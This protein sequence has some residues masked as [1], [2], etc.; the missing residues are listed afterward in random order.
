MTSP[1]VVPDRCPQCGADLPPGD[2][3]HIVCAYC[4]SSLI[5][6]TAP[7]AEAAEESESAGS[8]GVHLKQVSYVDRQ[9]VGCE[10]FRLLIPA[11][12][13]LEGGVQ[14]RMDNPG[15]PGV[16]AFRAYNPQGVEAFEVFPNISFYWT[17]NPMVTT[18][19]PVG[20]LY[21]GNEVRPPAPALQVLQEIVVPRYRGQESGLQVVQQEH[22]PDLPQQ[23]RTSGPA[24]S[25]GAASAEGARVRVR[26]RRGEREIEE[27]VFGVVEVSQVATPMP[28]MGGGMQNVFWMADY[29]FSFQAQAGQL[30]GLSDMFMALV[31]SFRLNPQW[32]ARYMQISQ[33]MIQNQMQQIQHIGQISQIISQT[34]DQ[35]SDMVMDSYNQ[36]QQTLDRLSTQFS[37]AIRGVDEY[38]DP[39]GDQGVEL[40]GGYNRA[41]SNG[42]GEYILTDDASFD[43]NMG[44]NVNW[45]T[46][47]RG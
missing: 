9:G 13:E 20:S 29:L 33:Y 5:R 41:W 7:R 23:L 27:D 14:W 8:W 25:A 37:Q 10:T 38:R 19:F 21:Y 2:S 12:W 3:E 36:R 32:Y 34:S 18:M 26:Y 44:S 11:D 17:N 22:L 16:I 40:P 46:M 35:I 31:R 39:F 4:G 30:D 6:Q 1:N 47:E 24:G 28:A 15:M 42:L 43:P 45:E